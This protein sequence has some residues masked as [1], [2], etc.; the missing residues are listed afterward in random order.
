M[1]DATLEEI[2]LDLELE[3][4][5]QGE[6]AWECVAC[7]GETY[8]D[9]CPWCG[10]NPSVT[11]SAFDALMAREMAGEVVPFSEYERVWFPDKVRSDG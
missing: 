2:Q 1:R 9:R 5:I 3:H 4:V 11:G 7:G 8:R 6:D 10:A